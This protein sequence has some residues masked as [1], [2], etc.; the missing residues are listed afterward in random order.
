MEGYAFWF[1]KG[2]KGHICVPFQRR[3][4]GASAGLLP[5]T[6]GMRV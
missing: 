5:E 4:P 3:K 2:Q 1:L 6:A